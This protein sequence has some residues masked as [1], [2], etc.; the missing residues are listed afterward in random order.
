M[1]HGEDWKTF[2]TNQENFITEEEREFIL[3]LSPLPKESELFYY[4][5]S[6]LTFEDLEKKSNKNLSSKSK[7][8]KSVSELIAID[9]LM[10]KL[11][12]DKHHHYEKLMEEGIESFKSLILLAKEPY[13]S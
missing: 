1:G 7:T 8:D 12:P 4:K 11:Y 3:L 13:G 2:S 9:I 10:R 5:Y 6:S